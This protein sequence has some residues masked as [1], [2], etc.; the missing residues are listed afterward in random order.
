MIQIVI[1]KSIQEILSV[2][3]IGTI[4]F[5]LPILKYLASEKYKSYN[6]I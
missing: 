6:K 1:A 2:I 4:F 5:L 3:G